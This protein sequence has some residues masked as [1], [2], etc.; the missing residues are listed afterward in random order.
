MDS[1]MRLD[2]GLLCLQMKQHSQNGL[3]K[4]REFVDTSKY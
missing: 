1:R 4:E 2:P 3:S